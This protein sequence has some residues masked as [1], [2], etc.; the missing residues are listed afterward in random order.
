MSSFPFPRAVR[1]LGSIA[2]L[3]LFGFAASGAETP[4]G[5]DAKTVVL[6]PFGVSAKPVGSFGFSVQILKD[7]LSQK[8]IEVTVDQVAP[9]SEAARKGL[10][11]LTQILS[12]DGREVQGFVA[13]FAQGGELNKKLMDRKPG[14]LLTLEIL[15]LGSKAPKRITL[16]EGAPAFGPDR[17]EANA[18]EATPGAIRVTSGGRRDPGN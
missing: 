15:V 2:G 14:D 5:G 13:S 16:V 7:G 3:A 18:Q 6:A 9:N 11:P 1:R 4:G 17:H 12:I 8:V 10:A